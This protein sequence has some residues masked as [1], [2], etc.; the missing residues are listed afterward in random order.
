MI[1]TAPWQR[2]HARLMEALPVRTHRRRADEP[3]PENVPPRHAGH[4][5]RSSAA[6]AQRRL[7]IRA[8][9]ARGLSVKQISLHMQLSDRCVENHLKAI[10][11]E[12]ARG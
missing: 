4:H 9:H 10:A 3:P 6:A 8:L 7:Q 11:E 1:T 2:A 12:E 5:T